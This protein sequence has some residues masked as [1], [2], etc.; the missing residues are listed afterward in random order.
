MD[1]VRT[2]GV[3]LGQV[4]ARVLGRSSLRRLDSAQLQR[5]EE[6]GQEAE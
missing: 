5:V 3:M 1:S 2:R 6:E 4:D